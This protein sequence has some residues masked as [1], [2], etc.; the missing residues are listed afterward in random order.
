VDGAHLTLITAGGND[1]LGGYSLGGLGRL[2]RFGGF[3]PSPDVA[4]P[5]TAATLHYIY[6][7]PPLLSDQ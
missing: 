3:S 4:I 2:W 6:N 1:Y 5:A 7:H